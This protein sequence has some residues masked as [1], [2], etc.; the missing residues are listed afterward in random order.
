MSKSDRGLVFGV[1]LGKS[2]NGLARIDYENKDITFLSSRPF[3]APEDRA[4]KSL[5]KVRREA[6]SIRRQL[7]RKST[8]KKHII[9]VLKQFGI[10][11]QECDSRWFETKKNGRLTDY[12]IKKSGA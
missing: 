2:G 5:A 3:K 6:R 1:D 7:D 11:G 4:G 9:K 10:I 12:Y 8:R